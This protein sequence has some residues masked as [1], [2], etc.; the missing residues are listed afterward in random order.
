MQIDLTPEQQA[1]VR[2]AVA[3]GRFERPEDAAQATLTLWIERERRRSEILAAVDVAK[4]SIDRGEG[5]D[6]TQASIRA[7]AD[8][9]RRRGPPAPKADANS[10]SLDC[11][12]SM[13]RIRRRA[14]VFC[15]SISLAFGAE[16]GSDASIASPHLCG[17]AAL[18]TKVDLAGST[19]WFDCMPA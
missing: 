14:M 19:C 18:G 5:T 12:R 1:F 2:Q 3:S 4:A 13:S 11:A 16:V 9:I 17:K 10:K 7:L 15:W 6:I 8:D